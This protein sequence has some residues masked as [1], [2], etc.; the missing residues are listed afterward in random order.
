MPL[1]LNIAK[2]SVYSRLFFDELLRKLSDEEIDLYSSSFSKDKIKMLNGYRALSDEG[3]FLV[4][5]MI[6]QLNFVRAQ[7]AVAV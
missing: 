5:R 4:K 1:P 2:I 3:K 6:G 7:G